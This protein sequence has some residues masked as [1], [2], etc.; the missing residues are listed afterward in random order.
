MN[1]WYKILNVSKNASFD[2]IKFAYKKLIL[3][4]HPDKGG[5]EEKFKKIQEAYEFCIN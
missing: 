3:L 1:D 4:N 5:D 2:E